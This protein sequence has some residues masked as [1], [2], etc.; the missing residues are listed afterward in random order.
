MS[1]EQRGVAAQVAAW[2]SEICRLAD[3]VAHALGGGMAF[4]KI[5]ATDEDYHEA[6]PA[7]IVEDAL[8]IGLRGIPEGFEIEILNGVAE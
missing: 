8:M 4:V 5:T 6:N 2:E 3:L 7:F 1:A